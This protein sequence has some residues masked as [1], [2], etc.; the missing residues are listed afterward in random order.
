M[1]ASLESILGATISDA[2][3]KYKGFLD[4][5]QGAY[6]T[7]RRNRQELSPQG[8]QQPATEAPSYDL[9]D[10]Y[11]DGVDEDDDL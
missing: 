9:E 3:G 1:L 5:L 7:V 10:D 8:A 2:G 4:S 11:D 6:D